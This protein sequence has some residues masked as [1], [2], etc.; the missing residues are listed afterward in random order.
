MLKPSAACL[1]LVNFLEILPKFEAG[2]KTG[3]LPEGA[4]VC[5]LFGWG[6]VSGNH[7]VGVMLASLMETQIWHLPASV[8]RERGGLN[9]E[10]MTSASTSIWEKVAPPAL[11]L[12][13]NNL[14]PP[15]M[16]LALLNCWPR[17]GA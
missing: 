7:Q 2:A 14:V 1:G 3:K 12:K 13:P 11:S 16:S 15:C 10:T 6:R 8:H 4:W 9:K 5:L 17:V